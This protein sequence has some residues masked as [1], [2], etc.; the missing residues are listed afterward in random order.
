MTRWRKY[1]EG[2]QTDEARGSRASEAG[3][4]TTHVKK[5]TNEAITHSL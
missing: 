4:G 5:K 3:G 2:G 1:T